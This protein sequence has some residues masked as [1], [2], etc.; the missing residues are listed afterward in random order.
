M[1]RMNGTI[2]RALALLLAMVMT[3][4]MVSCG[5]QE[6]EEESD[7]SDAEVE[8]NGGVEGESESAFPMTVTDQLGNSVTLDAPAERI[9]SG[10][11]ISSSCC[12]ALGLV[13][14]MV[15]TEE[16]SDKRP[17]YQ[18]AAPELIGGD[19]ANVG[20]AKAFDLEACLAAEPDL[21]ILPKKAKDYAATL[22]ESG[23]NA[24]V[25]NPESHE[26]LI[27]MVKLIGAVSGTDEA[28]NALVARYDEVM[29]MLAA[30][31]AN[32]AEEEKPVVYMCAPSSYLSTAPKD[33]Y[34]AFVIASAGGKNAA[35]ELEGDSWVDVSYEQIIAMNPDVIIIPTNNMANG[36]PDYTAAD[37]M[38]DPN[39]ADVTAVKNG[40]VYNMPAGLEAWDSPVPSGILGMQWL[41]AT[42]HSDLYSMEELVADATDFYQTFYGFTMDAS[43][44]T[45]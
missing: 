33:M 10:Y 9:V 11:Y 19:V 25:V 16:K 26:D 2:K 32:V 18:L 12:I 22:A 45:G 27:E 28:A 29:E 43:I 35:D 42:L 36:Q 4:A 23:I 24:I 17:I 39:L 6:A 3:L 13:D 5:S 40:A 31:T 38:A 15:G 14:K 8:V 1:N 7:D 41:L 30:L 34:Q 37:V 21:V 20:S 44:I